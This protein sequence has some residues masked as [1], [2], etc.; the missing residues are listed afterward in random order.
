MSEEAPVQSEVK[1]KVESLLEGF[2]HSFD[3]GDYLRAREI[4]GELHDLAPS[5]PSTN[6]FNLSRFVSCLLGEPRFPELWCCFNHFV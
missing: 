2:Q 1:A 5:H 4:A 6:E 3:D